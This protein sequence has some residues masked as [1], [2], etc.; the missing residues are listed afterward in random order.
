[1][2]RERALKVVLVLVGL[3]FVAAIYPVAMALWHP[4]PSDDT[5]DT[6]MM[7]LYFTLGV[8]LLLAARNPS[9]HG[10]LI[11]FTAWSSFA[12]A[13]VMSMLGFHLPSEQVG[14]WIGSAILALIGIALLALARPKQSVEQVLASAA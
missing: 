6:M 13:V 2:I 9:A 8:F 14:F 1:M 7:S 5:G 11:A 10:S 3:L 12:H 4:G